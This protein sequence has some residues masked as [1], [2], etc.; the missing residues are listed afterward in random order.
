MCSSLSSSLSL[1]PTHTHIHAHTH[2]CMHACAHTHMH[3]PHAAC[4]W[5]DGMPTEVLKSMESHDLAP[6]E[7]FSALW[8]DSLFVRTTLP[9][10]FVSMPSWREEV[11]AEAVGVHGQ[12]ELNFSPLLHGGSHGASH[13]YPLLLVLWFKF[14]G[15]LIPFRTRFSQGQNKGV[16]WLSTWAHWAHRVF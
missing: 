2:A 6:A 3:C 5:Q 9:K 8:N 14:Q 4:I 12:V 15:T 1:P 7:Y 13:R 11:G 16:Q 10:R